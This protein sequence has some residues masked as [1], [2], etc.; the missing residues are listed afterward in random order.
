MNKGIRYLLA[1]IAGAVTFALG[2]IFQM[3][4]SKGILI[5]VI[6]CSAMVGAWKGIVGSKRKDNE[7]PE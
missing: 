4:V 7:K 1:F 3:Y 6:F 2:V 5:S